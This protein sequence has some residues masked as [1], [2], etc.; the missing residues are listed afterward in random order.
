MKM[1]KRKCSICEDEGDETHSGVLCLIK[2]MPNN[3]HTNS[4]KPIRN[5]TTCPLKITQFYRHDPKEEQEEP[6]WENQWRENQSRENQ[7]M[8]IYN[9]N[10]PG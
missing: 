6:A 5:L 1:M 7:R 10:V 3:G 8:E 2:W 9:G 4:R